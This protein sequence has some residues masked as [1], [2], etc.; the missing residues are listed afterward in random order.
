MTQI[1]CSG[2]FI[3]LPT[4]AASLLMAR[5]IHDSAVFSTEAW[6]L[7]SSTLQ[8]GQSVTVKVI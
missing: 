4:L 3:I 2:G 6:S 1:H 5:R 7:A 8:A